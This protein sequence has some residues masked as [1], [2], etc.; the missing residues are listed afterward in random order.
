MRVK[1]FL[2]GVVLLVTLTAVGITEA[3]TIDFDTL[4]D[5]E[6][7]IAQFT[8]LTF[9]NTTALTAGISLNEF[10][11]PPRSGDNVVFDD[12]GPMTITFA[13]PMA[14]FEAYFTYV[15]PLALSFYDAAS[16]LLG[17]ENS[18]FLSNLAL[19]GDPGSSP[20]ELI[21]FAW[22]AGFS[23]V[24]IEGDSAGGSFTMDDPTFNPPLTAVPEPTSALLLA[25]GLLSL[26]GFGLRRF[27]RF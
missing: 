22:I 23:K 25:G 9:S 2:I 11:F 14:D 26:V 6:V 19:S 15:V 8:G 21:A 7:V 10:E 3:V 1:L 20:N 4:S 24:V 13:S 16:N 27:R 18:A 5:S 17:T 12:S